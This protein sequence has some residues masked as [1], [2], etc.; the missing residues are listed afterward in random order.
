MVRPIMNEKPPRSGHIRVGTQ[1]SQRNEQTARLEAGFLTV[2]RR[3][4]LPK[5]MR[6]LAKIGASEPAKIRL[7]KVLSWSALRSIE[8]GA[9]CRRPR[10]REGRGRRAR[11]DTN[12]GQRPAL[13]SRCPP[14]RRCRRPDRGIRRSWREAEAGVGRAWL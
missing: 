1:A 9:V 12:A 11:A 6:F 2:W 4:R 8:R 14:R 5:R 7:G 13:Y 3:S 10:R